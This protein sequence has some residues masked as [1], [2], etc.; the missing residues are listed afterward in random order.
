MGNKGRNARNYILN[1]FGNMNDNFAD[2]KESLSINELLVFFQNLEGNRNYQNIFK[3]K[4]EDGYNS[5]SK[6]K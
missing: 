4:T 3:N 2:L 1:N 5:R 6:L